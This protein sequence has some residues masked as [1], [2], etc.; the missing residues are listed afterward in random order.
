[1]TRLLAIA[2]AAGFLAGAGAASAC[3]WH[4][5]TAGLGHDTLAKAA[6]Q[7]PGEA[8]TAKPVTVAGKI[9]GN[10]SPMAMSLPS[11]EATR[12]ASGLATP[13]Q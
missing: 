9:I 5:T 4:K 10:G 6:V 3:E 11:D 13:Q 12:L 8:G 1:M 2:A 7:P